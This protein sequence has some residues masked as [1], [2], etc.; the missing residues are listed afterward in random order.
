MTSS[1]YMVRTGTTFTGEQ[2]RL[3]AMRRRLGD[4]DVVGLIYRFDHYDI[5]TEAEALHWE[6]N[7]LPFGWWIASAS[8]ALDTR[9]PQGSRPEESL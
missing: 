5:L 9:D 1:A 6:R 3:E 2:L 8:R 4:P 7:V